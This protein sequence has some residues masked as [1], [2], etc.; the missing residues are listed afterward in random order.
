M[1]PA[2][3]V[4]RRGARNHPDPGTVPAMKQI[5]LPTRIASSGATSRCTLGLTDLYPSFDGR[6]YPPAKLRRATRIGAVPVRRPNCDHRGCRVRGGRG[7]PLR[8]P[9]ATAAETRT[10]GWATTPKDSLH[11][12]DVVFASPTWSTCAAPIA[13]G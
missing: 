3:S 12:V 9:S 2:E 10:L 4:A 6:I 7:Q 5:T 13:S 8:H 1:L 11:R